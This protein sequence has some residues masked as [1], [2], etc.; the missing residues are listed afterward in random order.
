[1]AVVSM[2]QLLEAGVHFGHQTRR[3]N[4]K[5][6]KFIFTERNGIY[7]IDL[8]KTVKKVE[9][10]YDFLREVAQNGEVVLFVGTKKQAQESVK[11]EA[12]RAN[13]FYVNERWLGGMLT[14]FKT[15]ET[16]VKR[17]KQLETMAEDGTFELLPKKEVIGLRHEM[18]KLEKYLGGIKDMPK[19]PGALFVIDPKKE[20]IAIAEAKKLGI[21]VVATVD[22]NCDPDEIDFPIPANDDAIRA[23]KLL[24]GKMA[25]AVLEGRQGESLDDQGE[26]QEAADQ[27]LAQMVSDSVDMVQDGQG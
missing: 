19:M 2:K 12:I 20:R 11:E 17:L 3:W 14:N 16:R 7:I 22:T 21:P 1:M 13:M 24:T 6:A 27:A 8:Q 25:D 10:A 15:I 26:H 4:P 23:V 5:M 18:E 9:E